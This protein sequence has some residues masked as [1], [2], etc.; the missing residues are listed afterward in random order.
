ML[1]ADKFVRSISE[2]Q[3]MKPTVTTS[4]RSTRWMM[5]VSSARENSDRMAWSLAVSLSLVI[6]LVASSS[7]S[8]STFGSSRPLSILIFVGYA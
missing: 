7:F 5:R 6:P 3:Y 1:A 4:R 2:M 8:M